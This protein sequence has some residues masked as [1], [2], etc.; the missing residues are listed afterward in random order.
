MTDTLR[1]IT[2]QQLCAEGLEE[3]S[4]GEALARAGW[5]KY[6]TGLN[7]IKAQHPG[8]QGERAFGEA[9][10]AANLDVWPSDGMSGK[11]PDIKIEDKVRTAAMW[12]AGLTPDELA[13]FEA[14][15]AKTE[16]TAKGGFRGLHAAVLRAAS[17][18]TS[19]AK[20]EAPA[21]ASTAATAQGDAI[22]QRSYLAGIEA[23]KASGYYLDAASLPKSEQKKLET[24]KRQTLKHMNTVLDEAEARIKFEAAKDNR[25]FID[26]VIIPQWG[27]KI[28][29]AEVIERSHRGVM[30]KAE[31]NT[32]RMCL[33][34][35]RLESLDREQLG[36]AFRI[37][38]SKSIALLPG[39]GYADGQPSRPADL[40]A[41][42]RAKAEQEL[43]EKAAKAATARAA[44]AAAA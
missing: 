4:S 1:N 40:E 15:H 18:S 30:T 3:V 27:D 28:A 22:C 19:Q 31:Y 21:A 13:A 39:D 41:R 29:R 42:V 6:G 32:V 9:V 43:R 38:N 37:F 26:E 7:Q 8:K 44:L 17:Q 11:L 5:L 20:P 16:V 33:H 10:K 25:R 12:A 36:Q 34:P 35:D 2:P 14:A 23:A 24:F